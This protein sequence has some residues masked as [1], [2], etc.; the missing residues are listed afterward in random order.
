MK[1]MKTEPTTMMRLV[2]KLKRKK[3]NNM[4]KMAQRIKI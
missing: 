3:L 1:L 4:E 2:K